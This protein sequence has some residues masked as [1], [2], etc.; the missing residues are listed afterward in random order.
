MINERALVKLMKEAW[1]ASGYSVAEFDSGTVRR[2]IITGRGWLVACD[3]PLLPRK[4][5][6]MIAE[7]VGAML[8]DEALRVRKDEEPQRVMPDAIIGAFCDF[9]GQRGV[10]MHRTRLT[11]D[12]L[13]VW[14][15][16]KG[17]LLLIDPEVSSLAFITNDWTAVRSGDALT[18][19]AGGEFVAVTK[20]CDDLHPGLEKLAKIWWEE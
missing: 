7:H 13:E 1:K 19:D 18:V 17:E 12:R 5:L 11:M 8:R 10:G 6:G 2:Y 4:A 20:V 15:D 16:E 3:A 14:Q 9:Y